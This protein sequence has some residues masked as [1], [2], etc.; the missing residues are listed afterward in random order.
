MIT[1]T[2]KNAGG[3]LDTRQA[4]TAARAAKAAAEMIADNGGLYDGDRI[5]V[6]GDEDE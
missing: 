4:P 5:E 3:V 2:L 1:V 6:T